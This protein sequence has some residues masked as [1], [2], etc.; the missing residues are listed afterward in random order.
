MEYDIE[1]YHEGMRTLENAYLSMCEYE[2]IESAH[3]EARKCKRYRPDVMLFCDDLDSNLITIQNELKWKQYEIGPYK[4]FY[5]YEPKMRLVMAIQYRDRVV[6]WCIYK[7]LN[8]FYDRLF[9]ADSYACR[10]G[11][12]SHAAAD[13]LQYWLKQVSR[14]ER[15]NR[16]VKYYYLKLDIAKYFYRVSH[17]ILFEILKVR[18]HDPDMLW[19]LEKIINSET[20]KFGLPSGMSPEECDYDLWLDDVG[21]PIG[22]LTSQLFANIYLDQLDKFCKHTLRIHYYIRYMDDIII[23]SESKESLKHHLAE[24]RCYLHDALALD[25]N[26]KT[27]IRPIDAGIEFVGYRMWATHR[28]LKVETARKIIRKVS[29]MCEDLANGSL[30]EEEFTRKAASY[31]GVMM[32]CNS[33]GMRKKLNCKYARAKNLLKA[34]NGG[35]N[36]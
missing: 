30:S 2:F 18:I 21:I 28:K 19:L 36:R 22:N 11:K 8:P 4:T 27:A 25:L 34:K 17:D 9:I 14:R 29:A 32:H 1:H 13:R 16:G 20:Q 26:N 33:N 3:R 24:I 7:V 23:L 5:V 12:G 31:N 15:E 6:Q 10:I 35:V